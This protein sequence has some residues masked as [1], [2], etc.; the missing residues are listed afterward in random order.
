MKEPARLITTASILLPQTFLKKK[1]MKPL[2]TN[3]RK[4]SACM[5]EMVNFY[6]FYYISEFSLNFA[7]CFIGNGY[8]TT[9]V[10]REIL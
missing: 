5:T 8:I 3:L 1:T 4:L 7:P 2:R 6:F 9:A 10:L